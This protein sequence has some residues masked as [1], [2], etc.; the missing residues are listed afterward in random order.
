[1][2]DVNPI[3]PYQAP[4]SSTVPPSPG[5]GRGE[6]KAALPWVPTEAMIFGW[7]QTLKAPLSILLFFIASL[8]ASVVTAP[9]AIINQF[10]Q[11]SA[12]SNTRTLGWIIYGVGVFIGVFISLWMQLGLVRYSIAV[13]RGKLTGAGFR[14]LFGG[15][16]YFAFLGAS[17]LIWLGTTLGLAACIVPGIILALGWMMY[18]YLLVDRNLGPIEAI[19]TSWR[20]TSGHKGN[21][22]L[23]ALLYILVILLGYLACCVGVVVALPV[24][25]FALVYV[26]LKLCGEEPPVLQ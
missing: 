3:N 4:S 22:F 20:I 12:D 24:V 2:T 6:L 7:K 23:F 11:Q 19:T 26:Y 16:P 1:M 9:A 13:V 10:M 17:I 14:E 8:V 21:L 5:S 18:G 15:G 25:Q